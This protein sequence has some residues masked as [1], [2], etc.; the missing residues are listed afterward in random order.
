MKIFLNLNIL[1]CYLILYNP[2]YCQKNLAQIVNEAYN[3]R[4]NK[5]NQIENNNINAVWNKLKL[6]DQ[7]NNILLEH[8]NNDILY[9]QTHTLMVE[10]NELIGSFVSNPSETQRLKQFLLNNMIN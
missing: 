3:S 8:P 4:Q 6:A 10:A 2:I 7:N 9:Q 1:V 5:Q